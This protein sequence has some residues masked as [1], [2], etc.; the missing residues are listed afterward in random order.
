MRPG[1]G[2]AILVLALGCGDDEL[3]NAH[4][5]GVLQGEIRDGTTGEVI[6]SAT[7]SVVVEGEA[8]TGTTDE[9]GWFVI[10]G[11]PAGSEL[12]ADIEADG[13]ATVRMMVMI[14]D[15][16]GEHP[17]SNSIDTL[18]IQL[19]QNGH[20]LMATV[21]DLDSDEA[22]EDVVVT[23]RHGCEFPG[24]I[25]GILQDVTNA[26]GEATLT[27]VATGQSY[28]VSTVPGGKY[29]SASACFT[30]GESDE[31]LELF[32]VPLSCDGEPDF[33]CDYDNPCGLAEDGVCDCEGCAW[34]D[35]D[36]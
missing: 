3:A 2:A 24:N 16:A 28:R 31:P 30:H 4:P 35:D 14:D 36:C 15:T 22:A 8:R 26:Q 33:C 1:F 11:L 10:D 32:V 19:F 21:T 7:V 34:D 23:A 6:L 5:N 12:T 17:Q 29:H 18:L 25:L 13:Y 9:T 20:T 27:G